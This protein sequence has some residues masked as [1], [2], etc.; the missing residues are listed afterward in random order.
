LAELVST[1][2]VYRDLL[3]NLKNQIR[4][5][6]VRTALAANRELVLLYWQIGPQIK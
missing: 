6:R 2:R 4:T 3:A 1:S 5:A